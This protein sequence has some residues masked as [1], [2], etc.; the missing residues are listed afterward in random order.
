MNGDLNM[1]S[2]LNSIPNPDMGNELGNITNPI[3]PG[4]LTAP[5]IPT[6]SDPSKKKMVDDS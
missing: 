4:F 6:S 1:D 2:D 3:D 5:A